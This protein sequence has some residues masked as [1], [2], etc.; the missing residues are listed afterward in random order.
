MSAFEFGATMLACVVALVALL[1]CGY[2]K[3]MQKA[4]EKQ[5]AAIQAEPQRSEWYWR[6]FILAR[7]NRH[8]PAKVQGEIAKIV[9]MITNPIGENAGI[10]KQQYRAE[11]IRAVAQGW[12][13]GGASK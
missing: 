9:C 12:S 6:A 4:A 7:D 8:D 10:A 1:Y 11:A 13:D 5:L 3:D 2:A